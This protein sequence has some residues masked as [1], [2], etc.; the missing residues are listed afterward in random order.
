MAEADRLTLSGWGLIL[1]AS[2]GFGEATA[3]AL[4]RH[5]VDIF[6]VHLDR[7]ATM[8][9][10]ERIVAEIRGLG[11]QAEFFNLNAADEDKRREVIAAIAAR[12]ATV[13][14]LL[15]SLAFGTLRPF[16]HGEPKE[17]LSRQQMDMTLDVMAH[18][19]VYWTQDLAAGGLFA[20]GA[21]IYAMTST[22]SGRV[23]PTYGAVSAAKSALESHIR[24]LALE[25]APRGI[26]ANAIMAGVTDTPA[27]RKI[28]GH[29]KMIEVA[30]ARNP[31]GRLT[32][33]ADVAQ[34][35]CALSF[36]PAGWVTGNTICV[37]GGEEIVG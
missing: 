26:S 30:R 13:R 29:E 37:D 17:A 1:G 3:L 7:R 16:I 19:L 14:V 18:S 35:I 6:G 24:Q 12:A 33:P 2:S 9:N 4:A 15:H 27:L 5:G 25:L 36:G 34:V 23:W 28:P 32:T 8:P 20:P 10:V 21:R 11:R 31:H 22:G